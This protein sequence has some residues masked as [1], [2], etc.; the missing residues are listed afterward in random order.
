MGQKKNKHIEPNDPEN[1]TIDHN[2]ID[3]LFQEYKTYE[4]EDDEETKRD[5]EFWNYLYADIDQHVKKELMDQSISETDSAYE[6]FSER[7]GLFVKTLLK[8]EQKEHY[9]YCDKLMDIMEIEKNMCWNYLHFYKNIKAKRLTF[10]LN[11]FKNHYM[12]FIDYG[13]EYNYNLDQ[14]IKDLKK[15]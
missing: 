13:R 15:D 11:S 5:I 7:M 8:N 6:L 14:A 9:E 3:T 12:K 4:E 10:H 2:Q 1:D